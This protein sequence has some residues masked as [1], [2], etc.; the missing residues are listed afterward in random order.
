MCSYMVEYFFL[1]C[2][3]QTKPSYFHLF[4]SSASKLSLVP[5]SPASVVVQK[6]LHR[7]FLWG[8][9]EFQIARTFETTGLDFA[10]TKQRLETMSPLRLRCHADVSRLHLLRL[11]KLQVN[12]RERY[13]FRKLSYS[14]IQNY[15]LLVF[16]FTERLETWLQRKSLFLNRCFET[17]TFRIR[18]ILSE[19]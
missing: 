9:W 2:A 7:I 8:F 17:T 6:I 4:L 18:I 13:M 10:Q 12:W 5:F 14:L 19:V 15:K 1:V 11:I 16:L 3:I